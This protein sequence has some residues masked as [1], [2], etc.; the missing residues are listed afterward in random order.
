M[1]NPIGKRI[2]KEEMDKMRK[3]YNE[4]TNFET[5]SV[6]FDRA[7]FER[8]LAVP[9]TVGVRVYYGVGDDKQLHTI[10][11]PVGEGDKN[12]YS[13]KGI[14]TIEEY[15]NTCPPFCPPEL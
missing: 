7:T 10:F 5:Q 6:Y 8:L 2:S 11:V 14:S 12:I 3:S 15:G 9:G 4:Q 1:A 13:E